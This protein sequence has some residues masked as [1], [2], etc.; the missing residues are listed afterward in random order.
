MPVIT[1]ISDRKTEDFFLGRLKGQILSICEDVQIIDLAHNIG[2]HSISRAAFILKNSWRHFPKGTVHIIGVDGECLEDRKHIIA[3]VYDQY[4]IT[5][6][7]GLLSLVFGKNELKE[8][9]KIEICREGT[10][11]TPALFDFGKTACKIIKGTKTGELGTKTSEY[12]RLTAIKP[13][14]GDSHILGQMV[15]KD[16]YGNAVSNITFDLFQEVGKGRSYVIYAGST[17]NK[18]NKIS[19]RYQDVEEGELA[20]VF[21]SM[22]LLEIAMNK[23]NLAELM[24]FSKD[25]Q[26]R[27]EFK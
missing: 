13:S 11:M 12:K 1:L 4:F 20:A 21:N 23:G 3:E 17:A 6:D 25:T 7:N 8:V 9:I 19:I 24:N 27:I 22:G 2:Y 10:V 15:Y 5:S 14:Y 18:I 16:S 26:I